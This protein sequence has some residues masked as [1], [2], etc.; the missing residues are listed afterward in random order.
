MSLNGNDLE[1]YA[2]THRQL[3]LAIGDL[4]EAALQWKPAPEKWSV[5]EVLSHLLDHH[6]V[7][8]FRIRAILA[9]SADRLPAFDQDRW[10]SGSRANKGSAADILALF[11]ALLVNNRLLFGR[12]SADDWE[13]TGVNAKGETVALWKIVQ[14]F[15]AHLQV[16]LT[17]IERNKQ[18]A[19]A[20]IAESPLG[21]QRS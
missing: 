13:K 1:A 8:S 2:H 12:L 5:T 16:H 15:V 7:V 20:A 6:L 4:D 14:S 18:S 11:D 10:V 17:Q 3:V 19:S 21:G 9:G